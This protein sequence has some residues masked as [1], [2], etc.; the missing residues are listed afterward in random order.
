MAIDPSSYSAPLAKEIVTSYNRLLEVASSYSKR[1]DKI[2]DFTGGMASVA[3]II[4][5]HIGWGTLLISWYTK[6]LEGKQPEMPGAGYRKWDYT[7]IARHFYNTYAY[8]GSE[9]QLKAFQD[10]VT[11]IVDF[12]ELS[13]KNGT[14]DK[15]G[16]WPWCTLASGKQWP[17]SKWVTVNTVAPYKRAIILLKA[18][19]E[20]TPF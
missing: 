1:H 2:F 10:I 3:D 12:V 15:L 20:K 5:Y 14:L 16:I 13:Y 19:I 18:K 11:I 8:S 4:A 6:G 7:A 17:L 9:E